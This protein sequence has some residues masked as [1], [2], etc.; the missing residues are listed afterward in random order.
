[1][2]IL[3]FSFETHL[4]FSKPISDHDFVLRCQP[5][6]SPRQ[7]VLEATTLY[8]PACSI[9]QQTDGFGNM[10]QV[11]RIAREHDSFTFTSVGS[12]L[13]EADDVRPEHC[14]PMYARAS[15][16]TQA[17]PVIASFADDVLR[18]CPN[19]TAYDKALR[20]SRALH[21]A[22]TYEP[23]ATDVTTTAEQ[24]LEQRR[25]VCQDYTQALLALCRHAGVPARYVCG[26]IIGEGATHAWVEVHDGTR[27]RGIDPTNDKL[28][29]DD[30]I[31]IS[32]GRDFVDCPI[33]QGMFRGDAEQVQTVLV[34]V[35]DDSTAWDD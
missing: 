10:I 11:G 12:V 32:H 19:A 8:Q 3:N 31:K 13:V 5:V 22:M 17:G 24:A 23:G 25:G 34:E 14:H 9:A 33:E 2:K 30:Y 20:L 4:A 6:S 15:Q 21:A 7:T 16:M 18:V 28:V 26:L 29:D 27:W 1:M 35:T